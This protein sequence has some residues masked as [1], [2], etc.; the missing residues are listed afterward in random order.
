[1]RILIVIPHYFRGM[2]DQ[3]H[4]RSYQPSARQERAQALIAT[5]SSLHQTFG[6][7]LYG[8]DHQHAAAWQVAPA[9]RHEMNVVIC[10]TGGA[11]LLDEF[12]WLKPFYRHHATTVEPKLLGFECHQLLRD[13]AGRYDYYG[14]VEDDIAITDPMFFRKRR[15]F[16]RLFG[17]QALLQPN[18]YET[19]PDGPV[20][21]LYVD[22]HLRPEATASYQDISE[23]PRL[24]M[25]FVDETI[26]F[27]RT[28]YPSAGCFFLNAEQ[29]EIWSK[30]P[31]FLD[32]DTSYLS[33]LDSAVT[34]SVMKTFRIYKPALDQAAFLEAQH[35]S[36]RWING[37]KVKLM[38]RREPFSSHLGRE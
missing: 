16:D 1:M 32:G 34:L 21:K 36:P 33:A 13:A 5:V 17:S 15:L 2:S 31:Y 3:A 20:Q 24:H 11:H 27:E 19:R 28:T 30:G 29:L 22:Y 9:V 12:N 18:R 4:N 26:V 6:A 25:P 7:H 37:V 10:T 38:P 8:L 23:T 35:L 14:F